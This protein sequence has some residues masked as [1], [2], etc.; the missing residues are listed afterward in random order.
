[1]RTPVTMG[2]VHIIDGGS[3]SFEMFPKN[4]KKIQTAKSLYRSP[5]N[6]VMSTS[7]QEVNHL[8]ELFALRVTASTNHVLG[9][10][11]HSTAH[12]DFSHRQTAVLT[13]RTEGQGHMSVN[14][15]LHVIVV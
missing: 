4:K 8:S 14:F 1:M 7:T 2:T 10:G 13:D 9:N 6:S 15:W 5:L 11:N 3:C 12:D